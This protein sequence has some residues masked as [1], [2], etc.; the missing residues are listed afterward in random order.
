[1]MTVQTQS[2]RDRHVSPT[3]VHV[4]RLATKPTSGHRSAGHM[5]E[6]VRLLEPWRLLTSPVSWGIENIPRRRPSLFVGNHTLFSLDAPMMLVELYIRRR[7]VLRALGDHVHFRIPLWRDLLRRYGVV[8]GTRDNCARLMAAG[9]SVLV[10]P[11]GAREVFKHK[12]EKY[13]LLWGD[14]VGFARMAIQYRYPIVPFAAVGAEEAFDIVLDGD[15]VL[16]AALLQRLGFRTD[17]LVPIVKGIGPTLLPRP[18]RL[19]F[20]FAPAI[21]TGRYHGHCEDDAAC[22]EVRERV[23]RAIETGIEFLLQKRAAD[24]GRDLLPR[25]FGRPPAGAMQRAAPSG[26]ETLLRTSRARP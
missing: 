1:M 14:R 16:P 18:E 23:K 20:H 13:Q 2:S 19:Y 25:L 26:D 7:F 17:A 8:D 22:W 21:E 5:A 9:E 15:T 6:L 11:G 4:P 12:G 24:P 3:V 10:F